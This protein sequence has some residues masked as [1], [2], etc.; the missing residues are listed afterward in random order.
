MND[1]TFADDRM[2]KV[3]KRISAIY[4]QADKELTEKVDSFFESFERLDEQKAQMVESGE[5]TEQEYQEWRKNKMLMGQK[6]K[7]LRDTM[8]ERMV[9]ADEIA[10]AYM[11]GQLP[12][13]YA[14]N[15]NLVGTEATRLVKGFSFDLVNEQAVRRLSTSQKTLLPYKIVDGRRATRW[16]TKRVNAAILQGII[17]GES[18]PK[19]AK[20]LQNVTKMNEDSAKRNA[21]T[22][23][24]GAQNKGRV[25]AM[26]NLAQ[27]GLPI[28]KKWYATTGDGRTR[29]AHLEL[30]LTSV[31]YDKPFEN[32]IG[33]I[34]YPGDPNA[35]PANT[36]N[37]RC[38]IVTDFSEVLKQAKEKTLSEEEKKEHEYQELEDQ[39][40]AM[41]DRIDDFHNREYRLE[42]EQREAK[43]MLQLLDSQDKYKKYDRFDSLDDYKAFIKTKSNEAQKLEDEIRELRR[44]W[45]ESKNQSDSAFEEYQRERQNL[46]ERKQKAEGIVYQPFPDWDKVELYRKAK[47]MGIDKIRERLQSIPEEIK[48]I[49]AQRSKAEEKYYALRG[50]ITHD[51]PIQDFVANMKQKNVKQIIPVK[52]SVNDIVSR[53]AGG[54][55]TEG[56]CASLAFCYAGQKSGYDV[57][58]FR[59]GA[60]RKVISLQ[61]NNIL[62]YFGRKH[63][64]SF[65]SQTA[66][67][68]TTAGH[69]L[70]LKANMEFGKEYYF[71]C[72]KHAAIIRKKQYDGGM[73]YIEYLELQSADQ[74]GWTPLAEESDKT[75]MDFSLS[76]RFAAGKTI[77]ESTLDA[78]ANL[79]DISCLKDDSEFMEMLGY[80]NTAEDEQRKGSEGHE[81]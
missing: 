79:L 14:H 73:T 40:S 69:K 60:S 4:R 63:E 46:I 27:K 67:T 77:K 32:S 7:D 41:Q 47:S 28:K 17:Q 65:K 9:K 74:N 37:C 43:E 81:R 31:D 66:Q 6:Y 33:R 23:I 39:S 75:A 2:K 80:I 48:N 56:S 36:Y 72:G 19:I 22:A 78:K 18:I 50:K 44:K 8:A 38:S 12:A 64:G 68:D 13:V 76:Y 71:T 58:D 15:Y 57:L 3:S 70:L 11:N 62:E 20:R 10:V 59:D 35:A 42:D 26:D 45:R 54:D 34:M 24:T 29:E 61:A 30:H 52:R 1:D 16:N 51:Y 55:M 25:D 5:I 53:I 21:R 49:K